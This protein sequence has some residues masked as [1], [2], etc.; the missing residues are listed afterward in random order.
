MVIAFS[1]C[2]FRQKV[3]LTDLKL[4]K[5]IAWNF[6][7]FGH[8]YPFLQP[9]CKSVPHKLL[10]QKIR[11]REPVSSPTCEQVSGHRGNIF[12]IL[13]GVEYLHVNN[14][15]KQKNRILS[16]CLS[17][18]IFGNIWKSIS[19]RWGNKQMVSWDLLR[20]KSSN[21]VRQRLKE[22]GAG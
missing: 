5:S 18:R 11:R 2:Y 17:A 20:H 9:I 21:I 15:N 13:T 14:W 8:F 12:W 7:Y 4:S 1:K 10:Y 3:R 16:T 22:S 19:Q 6:M